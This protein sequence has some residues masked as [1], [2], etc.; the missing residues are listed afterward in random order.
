MKKSVYCIALLVIIKLMLI[1]S[2][3]A[4][5]SKE[6]EE[7]EES[8]FY[9]VLDAALNEEVKVPVQECVQKIQEVPKLA[10]VG[11]ALV[12]SLGSSNVSNASIV[13]E[14]N[15]IEILCFAVEKGD[16][17]W[18]DRLTHSMFRYTYVADLNVQRKG[19]EATPLYLAIKYGY[20]EIAKLLLN[21]G[22]DTN[23]PAVRGRTP[24][25]LAESFGNRF[26][27]AVTKLIERKELWLREW[28]PLVV[29]IQ[30]SNVGDVIN[31]IESV[32]KK[33]QTSMLEF[34]LPIGKNIQELAHDLATKESVEFDRIN[35]DTVISCFLQDLEFT[36]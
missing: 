29:A 8:D 17:G 36:A 6:S 18:V 30:Q 31:F 1:Q 27:E 21:R 16:L 32:A 3:V 11:S 28:E 14:N 24:K 35:I 12:V 13:C 33:C 2:V 19:D 25:D 7:F 23:T 10:L 20:F 26:G 15:D 9:A 22:A 34:C 4:M 5:E